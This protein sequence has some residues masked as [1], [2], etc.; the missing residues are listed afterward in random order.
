MPFLHPKCNI[1]FLSGNPLQRIAIFLF[2]N[3]A[4]KRLLYLLSA[5]PFL[6]KFATYHIYHYS[7][8]LHATKKVKCPSKIDGHFSKGIFMKKIFKKGYIYYIPYSLYC[9]YNPKFLTFISLKK[10][11]YMQHL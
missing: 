10:Y 4:I 5:V 11:N 9:Q 1:V 2:M 8:N 7:Y 6:K 3:T